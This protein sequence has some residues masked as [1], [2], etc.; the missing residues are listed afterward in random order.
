MDKK[1]LKE[2]MQNNYLLVYQNIYTKKVEYVF[3]KTKDDMDNF[4]ETD[5]RIKRLVKILHKYRIEEVN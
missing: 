5:V 3:F 1:K 4:V 2:K